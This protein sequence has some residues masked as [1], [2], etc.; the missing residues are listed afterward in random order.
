MRPFHWAF[1]F[2][3][4]ALVYLIGRHVVLR[5][6]V[7]TS[8]APLWVHIGLLVL[9]VIAYTVWAFAVTAQLLTDFT[10]LYPG[11]NYR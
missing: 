7:R 4:Y 8:G 6:M 9:F 3:P 5:K 2:I 11:Y 10:A 1:A